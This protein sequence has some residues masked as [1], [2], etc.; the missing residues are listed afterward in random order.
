MVINKDYLRERILKEAGL[1]LTLPR[2]II[3]NILEEAK[4]HLSADDI[5]AQLHKDYSSV[6][7]ATVYRT[8]DLLTRLGLINKFDFGDGR[9]R[10]ELR[11]NKKHHHHLIC[12]LCGKVIDYKD[13]VDEETELVHKMEDR[14]CKKYVFKIEDY[15]FHFYGFCNNCNK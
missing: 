14:L 8:L 7:F 4:H 1:R 12:K 5:Y 3:L 15:Y 6:G 13:F 11:I 9:A 2:K 10:Y